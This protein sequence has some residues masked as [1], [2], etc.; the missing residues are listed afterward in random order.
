M[1]TQAVPHI[2]MIHR[3]KWMDYSINHWA[4]LTAHLQDGQ[5]LVHNNH[6]DNLMRPW[7]MGRKARVFRSWELASQRAAVTM[8]LEQ[9]AK[10]NGH[11]PWACLK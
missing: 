11:D 6:I 1:A 7:V 2:T 4:A 9:S 5:F 10:L 3:I 8:S